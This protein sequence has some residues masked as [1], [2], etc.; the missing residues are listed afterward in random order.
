[1][2]KGKPWSV[3][4]E[5]KLRDLLKSGMHVS[6]IAAELGK[7]VVAVDLKLRRLGLKDDDGRGTVVLSSSSGA[8]VPADILN[9]EEVARIHS[10]VI[11]ALMQPNLKPS[12][13]KRLKILE[14]A[15]WKHRVIAADLAKY[16][17][18]ERQVAELKRKFEELAG[19][20]KKKDLQAG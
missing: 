15:L 10:D 14:D 16:K 2:T 4:D 11:R 7:T 13:V 8:G 9:V 17:E 3:E 1:V 6:Q 20:S 19:A 18:M 12:E 5:V